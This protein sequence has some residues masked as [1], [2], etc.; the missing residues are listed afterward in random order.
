[1]IYYIGATVKVKWLVRILGLLLNA[2]MDS[3][4]KPSVEIVLRCLRCYVYYKVENVAMSGTKISGT[5]L[6]L[7][8]HQ[9]GQAQLDEFVQ[10]LRN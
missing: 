5:G 10:L 2:M 4:Y 1:M 7:R 3:V 9:D 6:C 8:S